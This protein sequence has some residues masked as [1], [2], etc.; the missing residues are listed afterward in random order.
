MGTPF[1]IGG[2]VHITV[3]GKGM[4]ISDKLNPAHNM[5]AISQTPISIRSRVFPGTFLEKGLH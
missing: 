3:F 4:V 1:A 2:P 5:R